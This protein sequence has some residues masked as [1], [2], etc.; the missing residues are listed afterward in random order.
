MHK[1]RKMLNDYYP[2][3]RRWE[4]TDDVLQNA[5]LRLHRSLAE[6]RPESVRHFIGL[7]AT[8]IR[9]SLMDLTRHHF[10]PEG[11][12]AHHHTDGNDIERNEIVNQAP[13]KPESLERWNHFHQCVETLPDKEREL[14]DLLWY[15]GL[16]QNE[17]ANV[18][19]VDLRTVKRRWQSARIMIHEALGGESPEK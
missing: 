1:T 4:Q 10:G 7:A 3:L 16:S 18:L 12:A 6:V 11:S 2:R 13:A 15:Q 8:Q 9:R 19:G 5:L 17:A 14:F